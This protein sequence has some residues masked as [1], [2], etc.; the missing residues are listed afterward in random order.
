MSLIEDS[1]GK[2]GL[3]EEPHEAENEERAAG[4]DGESVS[5]AYRLGYDP[6]NGDI[7]RNAGNVR[8]QRLTLY[9]SGL[10]QTLSSQLRVEFSI[11]RRTRR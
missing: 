1:L 9:E 3:T 7:V 2:E 8:N 5:C 4:A 6:E 10:G 11:A